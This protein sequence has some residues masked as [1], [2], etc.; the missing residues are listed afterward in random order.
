MARLDEIEKAVRGGRRTR[1]PVQVITPPPT[2]A[3][4]Q[5]GVSAESQRLMTERYGI[6]G[7][8]TSPAQPQ[9]QVVVPQPVTP[10]AA[11]PPPPPPTT[12]E[13][14][15]QI[16]R[17]QIV[18]LA[19]G[20]WKDDAGRLTIEFRPS[21]NIPQFL[22]TRSTPGGVY[23]SVREERLYLTDKNQTIVMAPF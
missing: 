16:G 14:A 20:R 15:A 23:A 7:V 11:P 4:P 5:A 22:V 1:P 10:Q 21:R 3:S 18:T 8:P 17:Q 6:R 19:E 9:Q 2:T 12:E 13:L